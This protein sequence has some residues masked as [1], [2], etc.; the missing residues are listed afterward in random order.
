MKRD[1]DALAKAT[2]YYS[3]ALRIGEWIHVSG[4]GPIDGQGNVVA[5]DIES[6]VGLTLSNIRRLVEA[7]G[8]N[9]AQ[10]V[11]CTCYLADIA[12]FE[13][14]DRVYGE[15]FRNAAA[16]PV[17][18]TVAAVLDGIKVEIDAVAYVGPQVP[19]RIG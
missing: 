5:G 15:F 11:K 3:P 2:G 6:E 10:I 18:T 1:T 17:R 16:A 14:F 13:A 7:A 12:D 9:V 19:C 4:Q 8:G